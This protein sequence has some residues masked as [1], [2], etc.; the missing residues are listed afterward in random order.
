MAFSESDWAG[1][2][3]KLVERTLGY[4]RSF[5]EPERCQRY[6]RRLQR[7]PCQPVG[8]DPLVDFVASKLTGDST[9]IDI[10]AAA[11]RWAI[12]LAKMAQRVTAVEPSAA[13]RKSL[14][15][16]A[17]AAGVDNITVVESS[18]ED[19]QL[20]PHDVVLN[21]HAM[22]GSADFVQL[23][24]SMQ[25]QASRYCFMVMRAYGHDGIMGELCRQVYGHPHDSPNF[26][27]GYNALLSKGITANVLA[28]PALK[29]WIDDSVERALVRAKRHLCIAPDDLSRDEFIR[30]MLAR[31]LVVREGQY[32][33]PDWM[34]SVL[35]WWPINT[36]SPRSDLGGRK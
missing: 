1:L 33:W 17:R 20:D 5:D 32:H 16:H 8:G 31:R 28:D 15:E 2:W 26:E 14:R 10:G 27:I 4:R 30:D 18:W 35:V 34:R 9:V 19:C 23:V 24:R 7:G 12:V 22:Y 3:R 6:L 13:L 25:Q 29:H 36:R 11:G 21:S